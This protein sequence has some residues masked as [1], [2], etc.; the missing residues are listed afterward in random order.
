MTI[1]HVTE[2]QYQ[3]EFKKLNIELLNSETE[4]K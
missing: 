1:C 3:I 4:F 2:S